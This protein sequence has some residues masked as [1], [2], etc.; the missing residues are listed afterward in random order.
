MSSSSTMLGR[1][2]RL[3]WTNF[4]RNRWLT[5]GATL[6]MALTLMMVSV[7]L[8]LTLLVRDTAEA[9]KQKIDLKIYF[10]DDAV[11]DEKI[12]ALS[13][14]VRL[15]DNVVAVSIISKAQALAIFNQS[16][17]IEDSIKKPLGPDYNPL[18]RT[19]QVATERAEQIP[20]LIETLKVI[21][22]DKIIC[23]RC[24]SYLK[25]KVVL[26][27]L[28]AQTRFVQRLGLFLSLFFGA[29]AIFNVLNIIRI[30]ISARSDEIEIMRFVGASNAFVRGPFVIEGVLYGLFGTIFTT[31]L[32]LI[33]AQV[34]SPHV[35]SA[36]GILGGSL[37]QYLIRHLSL[38]VGAQLA[39]GLGLG[40]VVSYFSVRR[41]LKA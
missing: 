6:L 33:G 25:N 19:I 23:D 21:D 22:S 10:N 34:A 29:I 12:T 36:F 24:L 30:T 28:I 20:A 37:Y 13:E 9:V 40:V 3:G 39:I 11:P 27:N 26:D 41:Y 1:V 17:E 18:P 7:S 32:L 5:L 4:W 2:V 16:S 31:A 38:I 15:Q 14:R 35:Q 8:L